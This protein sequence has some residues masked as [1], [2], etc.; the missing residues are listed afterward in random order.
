MN[1][2]LFKVILFSFILFVGLII[3][4]FLLCFG[5]QLFN[6]WFVLIKQKQKQKQNKNINEKLLFN[7]I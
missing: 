1:E 4:I 2:T 6:N 5:F 7:N 3:L